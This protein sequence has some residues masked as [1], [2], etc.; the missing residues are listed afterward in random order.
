[1]GSQEER[2]TCLQDTL[3]DLDKAIPELKPQHRLVVARDLTTRT[4]G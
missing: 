2:V 3:E 1:M 4:L